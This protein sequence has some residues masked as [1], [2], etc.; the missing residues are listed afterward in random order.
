MKP[1]R[2]YDQQLNMLAETDN[3]SSL[4]FTPRFY[5]VGEFE[6]HIN[7]YVEGAEYFVKG[8]LIVLDKRDDKAMIIRHREV[9]LDQNGKASENWR[10]TGVALKGVLDQRVT[11][12]PDGQSHDRIRDNAETVMK[13]YVN[14]HFVNPVDPTRKIDFIEIAEDQERG[15]KID[16]ES[17]FKNVSDELTTISKQANIGWIMYA[18]MG[19]GKWIFDVVEPRDV[20]QNNEAGLQPVFFSPDFSTIKTQQFVDNDNNF[21]NVGFVGG[22]GEGVERK[23]VKIG[24][25]EGTDLHE[26]FIDA[27]D[28]SETDEET[29]EEL[30]DE[31][32]EQLLIERGKRKM[33]EFETTFYLEAQILTPSINRSNDFAISTPFEYEKDFKLGDLVQV[34]NK[35]WNITM[36]APIT[37]FTEIHE[38]SGFILEAFFGEAQPTLITKIR[39]KFNELE[40]IEKQELPARLSV[41]RMREAIEFAE[42]GL[43]EEEKKR[44]EQALEILEESKEYTDEESYQVERGAKE[45]ADQQDAFYD[46][47]SKKDATEKSNKA[48]E[49]AQK[50]AEDQDKIVKDEAEQ[51][52]AEKSD[53]AREDAKDHA[54]QQDDIVRDDAAKDATDKANNAEDNAKGHADDR[55]DEAERNAKDYTDKNAVDWEAY[56]T[57]MLEIADRFDDTFEYVDGQLVDK[58]NFD[59]VY[60]IEDIDDMFENVVSTTKYETDI[61]GIVKDLESQGTTISQNTEKINAQASRVEIIEETV[62]DNEAE[63]EIVYDEIRGKVS[64]EYV[65]DEVG[66]VYKY[67]E[68]EFNQIA[69]Q[70]STKVE[71]DDVKSIFLQEADSFTFDANQINFDGHVFGEDATF[72]GVV[73]IIDE[74]Y[75]SIIDYAGIS[76]KGPY[77]E[78][79]IQAGGLYVE[80]LIDDREI[81][82][83][84]GAI[85]FDRGSGLTYL[86]QNLDG[87]GLSIDGSLTIG[88]GMT[89][90]RA[91]GIHLPGDNSIFSGITNQ[92]LLFDVN[93]NGSPE[94]LKVRTHDNLSNYEDVLWIASDGTLY[95]NPTYA[96]TTSGSTNVRIG[97][98]DSDGNSRF[99]RATSARKYKID[100]R[101]ATDIDPYKLLNLKPSSWIDKT[102]YQENGES[103]DGLTRYYGIIADEMEEIGLPEYV[104]YADGEVENI[105]ER[106]WT[107][108]LPI[109]KKIVEDLEEQN[110]DVQLLKNEF[111]I[112]KELVS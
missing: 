78:V 103:T 110:I 104:E 106:A 107:L 81:S 7:Q 102:E 35:K 59:D 64:A 10:V 96:N 62:S 21:K 92:N 101:R 54:N 11:I 46:E 58:V 6:L 68:T 16:W 55:V 97:L 12:P 25:A 51:D 19:R 26:V 86:S 14:N 82:V 29:E 109:I 53:R 74:E 31:E 33:R 41:E 22:Q 1:I 37:E 71:E 69:N 105:V 75:S 73:S 38:S 98:R 67:A 100:I 66:E 23:I 34:F 79:R 24:E 83:L 87:T 52:A 17:R 112:I 99:L 56:D 89:G 40:G 72:T 93:K 3:Y 5:E 32:Y 94:P 80:S 65:N 70:I 111:K 39:D 15:P 18:D 108:L 60:V 27:R 36:N 76:N 42:N 85:I 84:S 63:F 43:S 30:T 57:K 47:E 77:N 91:G 95:S 61:D 88:D 4:Q 20:T 50:H 28:V 44:L 9:A 45:Y 48:R 2:V 49:D 13:H 8:N 90:G